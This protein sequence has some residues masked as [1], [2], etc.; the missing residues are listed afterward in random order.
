MK[1]LV[2]GATGYIGGAVAKA[3]QAR[4][5]EVLGLARS[6][7]AAAK[8]QQAG[9]WAVMGDFGDRTSLV[10]AVLESSPDA[11][12]STASVGS[13]S[14]DANTFARDRDAVL[15]LET[16]LGNSGKTLIFTSGS[17][18]FGV[19]NRGQATQEVFAEDTPLPLPVSRFAPPGAGVPAMLATGFAGAMAA[20]VATEQLVL[21]ARGLRGI[22]VR[23]GLVYGHGGSFD[24]PALIEKIRRHG[25]GMHLGPGTTRQ[26][27]VHIDDLAELYCLALERAPRGASLHGVTDEVSLGELAAAI[28]RMTGAHGETV[29][30]EMPQM[31]GM[32]RLEQFGL[33]LTEYLPHSVLRLL[34]GAYSAPPNVATGISLCLNKRLS[35]EWTQRVLE[36][37]PKRRDIL[38]DVEFGSY[39]L[40]NA[41]GRLP[42][43]F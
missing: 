11:V 38:A 30:V 4:G 27:Y 28:S 7:R 2:T 8:L 23:P 31:L 36:W 21:N 22:V 19:F 34:Q 1:V 20:R 12:I 13:L 43:K 26:G 32:T 37:A 33:L 15:A 24:L 29:S 42:V 39:A 9:I 18:V 35:S 17:A 5:H 40:P 41:D 6:E 3:L 16:A 25:H 10:R 14:G